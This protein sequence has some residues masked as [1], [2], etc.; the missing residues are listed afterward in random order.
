MHNFIYT[1]YRKERNY[2]QYDSVIS[3]RL[4]PR[5]HKFLYKLN[6]INISSTLRSLIRAD[7]Y[8][9]EIEITQKEIRKMFNTFYLEN[10]RKE[11]SE[12]T[13]KRKKT[14]HLNIRLYESEKREIIRRS[15]NNI[16]NYIDLLIM[17][18]INN[19]SDKHENY[20]WG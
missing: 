14:K 7:L 5:F 16:N 20:R 2:K 10:G 6:P 18:F 3:I 9:G 1:N 19:I 13:Y 4:N 8:N 15:D 12:Y 11:I 17:E